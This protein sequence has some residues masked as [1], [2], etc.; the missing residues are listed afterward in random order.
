MAKKSS[1]KL[2]AQKASS[3]ATGSAATTA[4]IP[5]NDNPTETAH[6]LVWVKDGGAGWADQ[7][8]IEFYNATKQQWNGES[9][10]IEDGG[11]ITH[12]AKILP[13]NAKLTDG[14]CVI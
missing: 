14:G 11:E 12:W 6:Y 8:C 2:G 3:S 1:A 9:G 4:W 13:P 5:F 10:V 7:A